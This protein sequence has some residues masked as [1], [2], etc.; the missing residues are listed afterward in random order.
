LVGVGPLV[1]GLFFLG[2]ANGAWNVAMNVQGARVEQQ[3]GK[4]IMPRFHAGFSLGTVAGALIG[5]AM[6]AL[7][8]SVA[9][10][11]IAVALVIAVVVPLAV[12]AFL[13]DPSAEPQTPGAPRAVA[14][15]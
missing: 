2:F 15:N 3:L 7:H 14:L 5:A 10:H 9:I 4:S 11:L 8:V 6:V 13:P 1:V 12:Q